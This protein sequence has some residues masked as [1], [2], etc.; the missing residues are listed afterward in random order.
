MIEVVET[1]KDNDP[2]SF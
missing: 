1:I 2:V